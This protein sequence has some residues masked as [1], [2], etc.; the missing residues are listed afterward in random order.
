MRWRLKRLLKVYKQLIKIRNVAGD[1][2][3]RIKLMAMIAQTVRC[4]L[5]L[6]QIIKMINE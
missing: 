6:Q 5:T 2:I 4:D 1:G 3:N